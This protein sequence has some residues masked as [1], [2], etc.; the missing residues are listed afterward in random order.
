MKNN[1]PPG[2]E[3][4]SNPLNF[5]RNNPTSKSK[6]N[7]PIVKEPHINSPQLT[8]A[9]KRSRFFDKCVVS[10]YD[11]NE[12]DFKIT[13]EYEGDPIVPPTHKDITVERDLEIRYDTKLKE[14]QSTSKDSCEYEETIMSI[15]EECNKL[16]TSI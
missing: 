4:N 6:E 5:S 15:A 1:Q 10:E 2:K 16:K 7:Y 13:T 12:G 11:T 3:S 14:M 9:F 8:S